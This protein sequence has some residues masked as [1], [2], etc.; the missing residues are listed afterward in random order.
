MFSF[1]LSTRIIIIGWDIV[2][3][4]INVSTVWKISKLKAQ[5]SLKVLM[6]NVCSAEYLVYITWW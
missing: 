1:N 5:Y 6:H 3:E 4:W 2:T